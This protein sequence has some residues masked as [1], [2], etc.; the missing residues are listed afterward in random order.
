MD[1]LYVIMARTLYTFLVDHT[2]NSHRFSPDGHYS[3]MER[4]VRH[5]DFFFYFQLIMYGNIFNSVNM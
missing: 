2:I 3:I 1:F 5:R 4:I